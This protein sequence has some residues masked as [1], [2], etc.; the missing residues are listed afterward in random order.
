MVKHGMEICGGRA[1]GIIEFVF[2][3]RNENIP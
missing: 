1:L 2:S 3:V